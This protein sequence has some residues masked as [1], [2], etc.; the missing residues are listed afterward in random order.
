MGTSAPSVRQ[1]GTKK[2][3]KEAGHF[4]VVLVIAHPDHGQPVQKSVALLTAGFWDQSA[5]VTRSKV[6]RL[7]SLPAT[8]TTDGIRGAPL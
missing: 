2:R 3:L 5:G 1:Q 7:G 4:P 8:G 6:Q